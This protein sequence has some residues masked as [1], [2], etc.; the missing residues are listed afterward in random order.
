MKKKLAVFCHKG[1]GDGLI[2]AVISNNFHQN[3]WDTHTYHNTMGSLQSW[4]PH[5]PFLP[6]P[7][8]DAIA[9]VLSHYDLIVAFDH[10]TDPFLQKLIQEG[11]R[12]VPEQVRVVYPYP[13]KSI[14]QLP[15]YED[16]QMQPEK[17]FVENLHNFCKEVMGLEKT[18][19]N[20]GIIA[21][22][23]V[24]F[25]QYPN[26]VVFHVSSSREGKNWPIKKFIWLG[27]RLQKEGFTVAVLA[28][29]EKEQAPFFFLEKEG[30]LVPRITSL[31]DLAKYLYTSRYLVGND[32]GL[33]H[34]A[35]ALGLETLTIGRRKTEGLLWK[36]GWGQNIYL[37]PSSYIPNISGLRFRDTYWKRF[38]SKR[39]AYR[40]FQRLLLL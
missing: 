13:T 37:T 29:L 34:L 22:R 40:A 9:G 2:S 10:R 17:S 38:I 1:L 28:G 12:Q 23:D 32:S 7:H 15:Y 39:R 25:R 5:L 26:R 16:V 35:S 30:F 33:G 4:F 6:Y 36:P 31:H 20:N 14:F 27:K 19:K 11:K 24:R 8:S 21:P 18:T 3:N